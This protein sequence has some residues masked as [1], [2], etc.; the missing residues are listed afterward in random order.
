[1]SLRSKSQGRDNIYMYSNQN[2]N[3]SNI[4][5]DTKKEAKRQ[6]LK[7]ILIEKFTRK[8]GIKNYLPF[9]E[10]E[11]SKFLTENNLT[12]QDLKRLEDRI[13][14]ILIDMRNQET[15]RNDLTEGPNK[16][17][18]NFKESENYNNQC[19][20]KN[21]NQKSNQSVS[22]VVLPDLVN[23]NAINVN[24]PHSDA[25]SVRSKFSRMSGASH[26]SRFDEDNAKIKLAHM[27]EMNFLNKKGPKPERIDFAEHGDEW[28]AIVNYNQQLYKEDKILNKKKDIEIKRRIKEDL[29]NQVRMKYKKKHE[30]RLKEKEFDKVLLDHCDYLS[31]LERKRQE[32]YKEKVM[33]D[34][35]NRDKQL[36]DE[37]RKKRKE[38]IKEKKYDR[39]V[40]KNIKEEIEKDKERKIQKRKNEVEMLHQTLKENESNRQRKLENIKKEKYD[41]VK[42]IEE[43]NKVMERQE[44]ERKEYFK[45]IERFGNNF[46]STNANFVLKDLKKNSKDEEDKMRKFMEEK[47]KRYFY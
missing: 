15:L 29:D 42:A 20:R 10:E 31:E 3:S 16:Y 33:R 27:A 23:N 39:E 43:N 32:E 34:K 11:I 35:E 45:K 7:D 46:V 8:F 41:D 13:G 37:K 2:P 21:Q 4:F 12:E 25:I 26:L 47:E 44:N 14:N 18:N 19:M 22:D 28:N 30:E 17:Q 9:L 1:M 36:I 40:V 5:N 6:K 24:H 38:I